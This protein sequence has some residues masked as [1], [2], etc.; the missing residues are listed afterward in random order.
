MLYSAANFSLKFFRISQETTALQVLMGFDSA[1]F[2]VSREVIS[3]GHPQ[4][5]S[6]E[7]RW[8]SVGVGLREESETLQDRDQS[9]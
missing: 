2:P 9:S 3:S 1:F 6:A 7:E 5:P 4:L 8:G